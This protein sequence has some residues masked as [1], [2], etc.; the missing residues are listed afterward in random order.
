MEL[1]KGDII[2]EKSR[3]TG[4]VLATYTIERTDKKFA[5]SGKLKFTREPIKGKPN[6][7]VIHTTFR[8]GGIC[9]RI[10]TAKEV[11]G[12]TCEKCTC[13]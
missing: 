7:F 10:K 5:Y 2:E 9:T 3:R 13:Q 12:G 6:E 11:C 8:E 4:A 1:H